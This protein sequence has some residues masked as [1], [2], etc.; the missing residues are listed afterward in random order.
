[1]N[2][3]VTTYINGQHVGLSADTLLGMSKVT[4][5]GEIRDV[6]GNK[7]ENFSGLVYPKV[8]DKP[9]VYTTIGNTSV[10]YPQVFRIQNH[11]LFSG[12]TAVTNG[13]FEFS[14]MV[15]KGIGPQLGNGKISY[16]SRDEVTDA[17]GY[18]SNILVGGED[19]AGD[20]VV[21]GPGISLFMDNTSFISGG[22]TGRNPLMLAFLKD[23]VG[24]NH[25]D[26]GV[27]HDIVAVLDNDDA[28]PIGLNDSFEPDT[29]SYTTGSIQYPF[30]GLSAGFHSLLLKA[31]NVYDISAEK[32]IY[33][34]VADQQVPSVQQ[35][36]NFPNPVITDTKFVFAS[37]NITGDVDAEIQIYSL[38]GQLLKTIAK[39]IYESSGITQV[40]SWD[41]NGEN[42]NPLN[43]G[44]YPYR[45][46][47][48][49]SNGSFAQA[50]QKLVIVR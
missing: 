13:D 16:Y 47:L 7:M 8:F 49:G 18:Y 44:I 39:K 41:G 30:T 33:F 25:F 31:W 37:M 29:N 46:I 10:S 22:S 12:K 9:V 3:A 28:H 17:N 19:P 45:V 48:R 15:P 38:T 5:R 14:F 43:S 36:K 1:L 2:E 23:P 11:V 27:G 42:G 32:E 50:S 35:V 34:W 20:T 6:S 40:I 21:K 4:I 24:I 26:L